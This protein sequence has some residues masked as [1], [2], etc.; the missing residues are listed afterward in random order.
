MYIYMTRYI[1]F[2]DTRHEFCPK[3]LPLFHILPYK[4]QLINGGTGQDSLHM[5]TIF[6]RLNSLHWY[7]Y[8]V[9]LNPKKNR[10]FY[11]KKNTMPGCCVRNYKNRSKHGFRMFLFSQDEKRKHLAV[12]CDK[13]IQHSARLCEVCKYI[14][15]S[16]KNCI[17]RI[18]YLKII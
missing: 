8:V 7:I 9:H 11:K 15:L 2:R 16:I 17:I 13:S 14:I 1:K 12:K 6:E 18:C 10:N 3:C 4:I 5:A